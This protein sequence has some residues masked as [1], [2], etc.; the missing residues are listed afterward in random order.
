MKKRC[1]NPNSVY[2][3]NYGG[4]GITICD[5]WLEYAPFSEWAKANGYEKGLEIDRINND[6]NYY[7]ENCRFVTRSINGRNK[8]DNNVITAW[9]E[10]K[11]LVEWSEDPRCRV[12][13]DLIGERI[14]K[15]YSPEDA[16]SIPQNGFYGKSV[17]WAS[18][19][20]EAFGEFKRPPDWAQDPRCAVSYSTLRRRLQKGVL[21]E[22]A[23]LTPPGQDCTVS[24][25]FTL[26][27]LA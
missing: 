18:V 6:D 3:H 25:P 20:I 24:I 26:Q 14:K 15:G 7:P 4:R 22:I 16:I 27:S 13:A 12:S 8:R 9:S 21:P 5:D 1:L 2:Y 19:L 10:T 17:A 11:C 23:L